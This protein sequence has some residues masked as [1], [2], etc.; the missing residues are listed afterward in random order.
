[1]KAQNCILTTY[2]YCPRIFRTIL[3]AWDL[4]NLVE[5]LSC[6]QLPSFMSTLWTYIST[7]LNASPKTE[8]YTESQ[9]HAWLMTC[10][11]TLVALAA[12]VI[13]PEFWYLLDF[14]LHFLQ[15]AQRQ[16]PL[17]GCLLQ[18]LPF[19][20]MKSKRME[21]KCAV[22]RNKKVTLGFFARTNKL[23]SLAK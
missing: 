23:S 10:Q 11:L 4:E 18:H 8:F 12:V 13:S 3:E 2:W 22:A 15:L 6:T 9:K 5:I 17:Q 14:P 21:D 20:H 1:M 16:H 19:A 7:I